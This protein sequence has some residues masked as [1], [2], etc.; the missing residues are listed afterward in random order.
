M[1]I[2]ALFTGLPYISFDIAYG[3]DLIDYNVGIIVRNFDNKE[4]AKE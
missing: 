2:Q 4:Y 1:L 3:L